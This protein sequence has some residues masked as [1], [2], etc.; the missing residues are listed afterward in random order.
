MS[1][2]RGNLASRLSLF[3][4]QVIAWSCS[5][6]CSSVSTDSYREGP[7]WMQC[8]NLG[9]FLNLCV[10][11]GIP[12]DWVGCCCTFC[13][14]CSGSYSF[15][16]CSPTS[17]SACGF[18]KNSLDIQHTLRSSTAETLRKLWNF[19]LRPLYCCLHFGKCQFASSA[20]KYLL[21]IHSTSIRSCPRPM[22]H[23]VLFQARPPSPFQGP[24][25][26]LAIGREHNLWEKNFK[27]Q[28][29]LFSTALSCVIYI[30]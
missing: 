23:W 21:Q 13:F 14:K 22:L 3:S 17:G 8:L 10:W 29:Q 26:L 9:S 28:T 11:G 5:P 4:Y 6:K 12:C 15:R 25:G 30:P 20:A 2:M 16:T 1:P 7:D 19:S 18:L 24:Y 27:G